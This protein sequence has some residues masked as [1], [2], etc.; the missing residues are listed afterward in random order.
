MRN[1]LGMYLHGGE[2]SL[3]GLAAEDD[4]RPQRTA[5]DRE[6]RWRQRG[7]R[8]LRGGGAVR[9]ASGAAS[10]GRDLAGWRRRPTLGG[11][12]VGGAARGLCLGGGAWA[13]KRW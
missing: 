13:G 3:G 10:R 4:R 1:V 9:F 12:A 2:P 6:G 11:V 8:W 7:W 5:E